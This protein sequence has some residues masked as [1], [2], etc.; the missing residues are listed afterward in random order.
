MKLNKI[1]AT[2]AVLFC[3]MMLLESCS[4]SVLVDKWSDPL[5]DKT[6]LKKILVIAIRKDPIQRRIWE[7][8]FVGEFSKNGVNATSSYNLFPDAL[9]DT[10]QIIQTVQEKEFDGILVTRLL[11]AE[12]KTNYVEGSVTTEQQ[13]RYNN[14]RRRYDLYS[15][16]VEHPGY[17]ESQIIDRRAIDVWM[18]RNDERLIWSATSN[19]PERTSVAEVQDDIADLVI[20]ELVRSSIIKIRK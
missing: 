12:T 4:S 1:F 14:Y 3:L 13:Y 17:V 2:T 16:K 7:D 18:I 8:A 15:H 20:P 11:L 9:P 5:F 19:T 10:N 6:P